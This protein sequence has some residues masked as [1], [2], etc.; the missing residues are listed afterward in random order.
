MRIHR[1]IL[2]ITLAAVFAALL[3][4]A[5]AAAAIPHKQQSGWATIVNNTGHDYGGVPVAPLYSTS[6]VASGYGWIPNP[7]TT[8]RYVAQFQNYRVN[9]FYVVD[10]CASAFVWV[11]DPAVSKWASGRAADYQFYPGYSSAA[12]AEC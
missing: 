3:L 11:W 2:L 4:P 9:Y 6:F 7:T 5:A 8:E 10:I 1:G 12:K